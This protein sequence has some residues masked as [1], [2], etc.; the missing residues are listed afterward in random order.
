MSGLMQ[1]SANKMYRILCLGDTHCGHKFGATPPEWQDH[2][3]SSTKDAEIRRQCWQ[4]Y[5]EEVKKRG[6]YD[7][8]IANGDLIE[9]K[10]VRS[11]GV[12]LIVPDRHEQARM[13][14]AVLRVGMNQT[15][16]VVMTYGTDYHTGSGEDFEAVI[17]RDVQ[18]ES[19]GAVAHI[20]IGGVVF[21]AR[22]HVGG[23][24]VPHTRHT[25]I[26]RDRLWN[27]LWAE[28]GQCPK[29]NV[30]L[31]SHVH[32]HT[33]CGGPD[34]VAMTLPAL[35]GL[36]SRFGAR[37]MSGVVDFGFVVFTV[38]GGTWSWESVI[39]NITA[40]KAHVLKF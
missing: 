22:H 38:Q 11:E 8:I 17:A 31:R 15:T 33:Y 7:I 40:Q 10:G 29:A 24:Q 20:D 19:I 30:I 28:R 34:W 12:E 4:F 35:Q 25:A 9:G 23:S 18:A 27:L 39:A 1:D 32:Y 36:G 6:P 37:R 13:A 26:A 2:G 3:G 16:R 21:E 14:E 5:G